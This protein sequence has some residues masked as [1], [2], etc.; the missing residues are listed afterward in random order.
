MPCITSFLQ[1]SFYLSDQDRKFFVDERPSGIALSIVLSLCSR[2]LQ[3]LNILQE[4]L[5]SA[6]SLI[7]EKGQNPTKEALGIIDGQMRVFQSLIVGSKGPL[8]DIAGIEESLGYPEGISLKAISQLIGVVSFIFCPL[9]PT[10]N[11]R[12]H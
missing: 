7:I 6:L 2:L 4:L 11:D 8:S 12:C 3:R 5:K 10:E 1:D 9:P